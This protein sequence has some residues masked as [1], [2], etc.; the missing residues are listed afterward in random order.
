M[1]HA[2][3][4]K[5]VHVQ[6]E[7]DNRFYAEAEIVVPDKLEHIELPIDNIC[8]EPHAPPLSDVEAGTHRLSISG[9]EK[10]PFEVV[11]SIMARA[12]ERGELPA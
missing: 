4:A 11:Q 5:I 8:P 2:T 10:P 3:I 7:E 1:R 12:F 6:L 9:E